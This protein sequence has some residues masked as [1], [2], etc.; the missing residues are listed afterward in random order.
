MKSFGFDAITRSR[1]I[2]NICIC[3]CKEVNVRM[4][5]ILII[6]FWLN[7][8]TTEWEELLSGL[9]KW[10]QYELYTIYRSCVSQHNCQ[11]KCMR[12]IFKKKKKS[13]CCSQCA[14]KWNLLVWLGKCL[15]F[16]CLWRW[17]HF[18]WKMSRKIGNSK[19][20][21]IDKRVM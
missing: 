11:N 14:Q 19:N 8:A 1:V 16:Y 3:L 6:L 17:S 2:R 4:Q 13:Y 7:Q 21:G 9:Q 15:M 20:G 5:Y 12:I 10:M 18:P